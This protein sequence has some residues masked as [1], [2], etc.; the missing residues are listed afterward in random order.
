MKKVLIHIG[1][2]K[3]GS[4]SIQSAL[5]NLSSTN[6]NYPNIENNGHQ[7]IEIL[8]KKKR[9]HLNRG[10]HSSFKLKTRN[11]TQYYKFFSSKIKEELNSKNDLIISSEFLFNMTEDE[12]LELKK[13]LKEYNFQKVK[14]LCYVRRPDLY[15]LSHVQQEIKASTKFPQP[16]NFHCD[17]KKNIQK[18]I[19]HFGLDNVTIKEFSRNVL[20][21]NDVVE[22]FN[23]TIN[24][25]FKENIDLES[26]IDNTS[27]PS[28]AMYIMQQV[29]SYMETE[30]GLIHPTSNKIFK[31]LTSKKMK[32]KGTKAKLIKDIR[33]KILFN[34]SEDIKY[35][36][37]LFGIFQNLEI[38]NEDEIIELPTYNFVTEMLEDIN[39]EKMLDIALHCLVDSHG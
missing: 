1:T 23:K 20:F 28:E 2:P 7:N 16:S 36:N 30:D 10:L 4:T 39:R 19:K 14:I 32:N 9:K 25:F 6:I 27:M 35:L 26:R 37:K 13:M 15:Y 31:I 12:I 38:P 5:A 21:K 18:W 29:R 8:F 22:D 34:S 33:S 3:T 17:Y 24:T 11:Y